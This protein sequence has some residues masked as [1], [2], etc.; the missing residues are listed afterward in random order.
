MEQIS[1]A[2]WPENLKKERWENTTRW[3]YE[4]LQIYADDNWKD[5]NQN[6]ICNFVTSEFEKTYGEYWGCLT[7]DGYENIIYGSQPHTEESI[8]YDL[9][10]DLSFYIFKI[11]SNMRKLNK[12]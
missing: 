7:S 3:L 12:K 10:N 2:I 1:Y 5:G 8:R 6:K 4:A 9:P 11:F